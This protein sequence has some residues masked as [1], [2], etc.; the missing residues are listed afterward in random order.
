MKREFAKPVMD[1]LVRLARRVPWG[2]SR[3][4]LESRAEDIRAE[5]RYE[6]GMCDNHST[7][8]WLHEEADLYCYAAQ[9]RFPRE[10]DTLVD[11]MARSVE[12][13][14]IKPS[15]TLWTCT[16]CGNVERLNFLPDCCSFCNSPMICDDGRTTNSIREPDITD[17]FE[18]MHD[19]AEGDPA[20]NILLWQER[21]PKSV[22]KTH[23]I[24]DLLLQ[25]RMDMMQAIFGN[26]A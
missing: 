3:E 22:Y 21:A 7:A 11:E 9:V 25:N 15:S 17:C 23:I 5:A 12:R 4:K 24:D 1:E 26:A 6:S 2:P 16:G 18:V 20:A 19:A 14:M 8:R 10:G 13:T